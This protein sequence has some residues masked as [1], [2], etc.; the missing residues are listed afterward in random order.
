MSSDSESGSPPLKMARLEN[1]CDDQAHSNDAPLPTKAMPPYQCTGEN[2]F[3]EP[4]LVDRQ[5]VRWALRTEAEI[6]LAKLRSRENTSGIKPST[7]QKSGVTRESINT[8]RDD[9][10]NSKYLIDVY[11]QTEGSSATRYTSLPASISSSLSAEQH[12]F[13]RDLDKCKRTLNTDLCYFREADESFASLAKLDIELPPSFE[14]PDESGQLLAPP[15]LLFF[16]IILEGYMGY[17]VPNFHSSDPSISRAAVMGGSILASLTAWDYKGVRR[18]FKKLAGFLRGIKGQQLNSLL[19]LAAPYSQLRR[20][21]VVKINQFFLPRL[22]D[23]EKR[24]QTH[25]HSYTIKRPRYDPDNHDQSLYHSGDVD[26]FLQRS[27]ME[28]TLFDVLGRYGLNEEVYSIIRSF[29]SL[30]QVY[31]HN[32]LYRFANRLQQEELNPKFCEATTPESSLE[33]VYALG[34]NALTFTAAFPDEILRFTQRWHGEKNWYEE[35]FDDESTIWPRVSQL[36]MLDD[37]ADLVGALLDFDTSV[38][39]FA[40]DGVTVRGLPRAA[41]SLCTKTQIITPNVLQETRNR[42]RIVK[43]TDRPVQQPISLASLLFSPNLFLF[44]CLS[45]HYLSI[46]SEDSM[47][48]WSTRTA[49]TYH[50]ANTI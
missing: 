9:T 27:P 42:A 21:I 41:F 18:H 20:D 47:H 36:I 8:S 5:R 30:G 38:A 7:T 3:S 31:N 13:L 16:E 48:T 4:G 25:Y 2:F 44:D 35:N 1:V 24:I 14:E 45:L 50:N 22:V 10:L 6:R 29:S 46:S 49:I 26:I 12:A 34:R 28:R 37:K 19:S 32:D 23:E 39:A 40:F 15:N 43:V 33:F 11:P 17:C